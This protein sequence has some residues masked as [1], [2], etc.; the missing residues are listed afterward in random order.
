MRWSRV[1]PAIAGAYRVAASMPST[2]RSHLFVTATTDAI[3]R[4]ERSAGG[5][6]L[7]GAAQDWL[8]QYAPGDYG[9]VEKARFE[10]VYR[11]L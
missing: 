4:L 1:P 11:P 7:R 9:I 5:D 10:A 6:V 8:L 2:C 3:R